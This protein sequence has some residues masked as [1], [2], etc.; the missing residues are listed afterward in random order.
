MLPLFA[1]APGLLVLPILIG[2]FAY[3]YAYIRAAQ[4]PPL[5]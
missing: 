4:L 2:L 5:S 3:E 1:V